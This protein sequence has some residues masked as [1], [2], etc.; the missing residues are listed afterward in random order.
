MMIFIFFSIYIFIISFSGS[1]T[2]TRTSRTMLNSG[3]WALP[4]FI[5]EVSGNTLNISPLSVTFAIGFWFIHLCLSDWWGMSKSCTSITFTYYE[6]NSNV[7]ITILGEEGDEGELP[8][9]LCLL[10]IC[11]WKKAD[12]DSA[13][14]VETRPSWNNHIYIQTEKYC[15]GKE[16]C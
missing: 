2:L 14:I 9:V 15:E 3:N 11:W 10:W 1:S 7:Y 8:Q 12:T 16:H 13:L 4:D 6:Q 5:L